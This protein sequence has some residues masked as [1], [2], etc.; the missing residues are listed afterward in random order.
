MTVYHSP[1][2]PFGELASLSIPQFLARY[3]PDGV[4]AD[5]VVHRD[6]FSSEA[7]TYGSLRQKAS[8]A[9]WGLKHE[10]GV[11]PGDT[12]LA[13]VTNSNDF[14]ILA[15]ATWWLGAVFAPLNTSSTKKDI[16][17][18]LALIKPTHIATISSKL[19]DVQDAAASTKL[20]P[21]PQVFTVLSK[22]P[23]IPQFP[24]DIL[25]T[26]SKPLP[27]FDLGGKSAK[28]TP[29]T[30]CFSSGTTGK[31]KGV[32]ISHFNL[33]AN[34]MQLRTSLP[35]RLNSSVR[36]VWFTPYCH[37]YGLASVVL[38]GMW[39]GGSFFSLPSFDLELFCAKSSEIQ[40]TDMHLV[41]PVAL[42]LATSDVA[43]RYSVPSLQRIVVAA[44]PLKEALQRE[45]KSRFP[46]A[47][48]C[49]GYGLTECS[50]GVMHQITDKDSS[51]GTVGTLIAGTEARLV[52]PTT[53]R[54]VAPGDEGELWVR[55]PQVMMGYINDA[56]ATAATFS[57]DGWLRTGDIMRVDA[58][59]DFWVTDRLK[60]MIKYKG[61]Q[62]PPSELED[63]LLQHP[64]VTD[65]AVCA[66]YDDSQATEVPLA[67]VSLSPETISLPSSEIQSVLDEIRQWS[68]GQLAGYKR[69]RGGVF[70]LQTLPKTPTGKILRRL[71]PAKVKEERVERL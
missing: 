17:H 68:D 41:P 58:D 2:A 4:A 12:I 54:D 24:N 21:A 8:C 48:I 53:G 29:S 9:A 30:I 1:I 50:P 3:N 61:F 57:S 22:V 69:L 66:V 32:L 11:N 26:T 67:Y 20:N 38:A 52:S 33:V 42:L 13:I 39:A 6:T 23:S 28:D 27:P 49:Q 14:V 16:E 63:T 31:M 35:T 18:V 70:H 19:Q 44:A 60:E 59:G 56:A 43:R 40:A 7:L 34:I 10:L 46:R 15:H 71:L 51:C 45:L 64:S 25:S 55:G 62:I 65:A 36:E 47:S 5:K 37:I